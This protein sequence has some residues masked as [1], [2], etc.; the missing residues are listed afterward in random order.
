MLS[1]EQRALLED[2][3]CVI[4]GVGDPARGATVE[5]SEGVYGQFFDDTGFAAVISRPDFYIF[6][7][8]ASLDDLPA[9]VDDLG[10]Q[11]GV[12]VPEGAPA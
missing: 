1:G 3:R 5:D 12:G 11:L 6:G 9:L 10:E 7:G 4:V 8:V 2:L